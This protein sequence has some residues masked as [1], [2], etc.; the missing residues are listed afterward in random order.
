MSRSPLRIG[1]CADDFGLSAAVNEACLNLAGAGRLSALSCMS[2]APAWAAGAAALRSCACATRLDKGLHLNLT[3]PFALTRW[4][5]P[6]GALIASAYLGL[7]PAA[8]LREEIAAQFDAF[9]DAMGCAPDFVDGHQH[10][11]QLP[12]V[13]EL[14]LNELLRRYPERR[15]WLRNTAPPA[16]RA[17]GTEAAA[18]GA[19]KQRLIAAL[20][21]TGLAGMARAIGYPQNRE[22]V[23]VYAFDGTAADYAARLQRW[24][25]ELGEGG[26]LMCHPAAAAPAGT[27]DP[28]AAAR[29]REYEVLRG[30]HFGQLLRERGLAVARLSDSLRV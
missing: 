25:A 3:E 21:A 5:R 16:R 17:H 1:I 23:G 19:R 10:V 27:A 13:R 14:L 7:L 4:H 11:H 26:L 9:E 6:L 18:A 15:P 28:I 12:R 24:C 29:M 22:L 2:T 8:R 30:G 20:G